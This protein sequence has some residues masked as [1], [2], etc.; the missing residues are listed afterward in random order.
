VARY[1]VERWGIGWY[2]ELGCARKVVVFSR[3]VG[4]EMLYEIDMDLEGLQQVFYF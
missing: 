2:W 3:G 1:S 4:G